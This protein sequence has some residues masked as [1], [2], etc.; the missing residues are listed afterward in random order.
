MTRTALL[1]LGASSLA[2]GSSSLAQ[3]PSLVQDPALD[4]LVHP[5]GYVP[6]KPATLGAVTRT[7][8]GSRSMILIPGLGFG[9]A[10]FDEFMA[11]HSREFTMY[12]VTLPGFGGTPAL[13]MPPADSSSYRLASWTRSSETAILALM[14]SLGIRRTTIVAHWI[15]ASQIALRLALR[16]PDRVDGVVL[17][18]GVAKAYYDNDTTMLHWPLDRRSRYADVMGSQWFRTVTRQTWDDNNFMSYDYA[19]NPRRGLFLWREAASPSL[20]VWIRYLLEFYA[21]DVTLDLAKLEVPVLVVQ[22]GFDDPAFLVEPG[23]NYMRNLTHD[24]WRDVVRAPGRIEFV[25]IP[26]ARL[27]VMYDQPDELDKALAR[28]FSR[29]R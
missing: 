20:P 26:G 15:L 22:P 7:G 24:S 13:A 14:D 1:I 8:S 18:G 4:N 2:I 3:R 5:T 21:L 11:R 19:V 25:T 10:V 29:T 27:F 28:F 6:A 23:R 9:G 17:L 16:H 12:A